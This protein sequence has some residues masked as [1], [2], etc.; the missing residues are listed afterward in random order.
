MTAVKNTHTDTERHT[1]R[2]THTHTS[3]LIHFY[4]E[5][6]LCKVRRIIVHIFYQNVN[7]LIHLGGGRQC[8]I[9]CIMNLEKFT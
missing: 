9:I 7:R 1:H 5:V 8:E 3:H 6:V 2:D 4:Y